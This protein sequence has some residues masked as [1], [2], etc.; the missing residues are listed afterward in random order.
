ML[1]DAATIAQM[2]KELEDARDQLL[3]ED[4]QRYQILMREISEEEKQR[5]LDNLTDR[6]ERVLFGLEPPAAKR[7][8]ARPAN[9]GGSLTCSLCGKA[10]LTERGLKP[11][12]GAN[13]QR[14]EREGITGW[15]LGVGAARSRGEPPTENGMEHVGPPHLP[16]L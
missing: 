2:E 7:S 9:S 3:R 14:R 8:G 16:R 12:H 5:I 4:G 11:P 1:M 6:Q 15:R 10:G 13:A